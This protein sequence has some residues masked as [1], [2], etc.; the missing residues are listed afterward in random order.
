[1]PCGVSIAT[2]SPP[3][4]PRCRAAAG[5]RTT[6]GSS[7]RLRKLGKAFFL[8]DQIVVDGLVWLVGFIPQASGFTLKLT[9]QRGYLQGYA[10]AMA[11]GIL[12]IL[13]VVFC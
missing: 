12:I 13:L 4:T 8:I 2:Q 6:S 9:T 10:G 1:M 5:C 3:A 11:F 7:A